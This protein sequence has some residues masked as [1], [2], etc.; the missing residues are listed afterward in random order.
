MFNMKKFIMLFAAFA[1]LCSCSKVGQDS[2]E[3]NTYYFKTDPS[4]EESLRSLFQADTLNV[5]KA[6]DDYA[7]VNIARSIVSDVHYEIFREDGEFMYSSDKFVQSTGSD[8]T[9][10]DFYWNE[11]VIFNGVHYYMFVGLPL[12]KGK[13][14]SP[15]D[16]CGDFGEPLTRVLTCN[17]YW[18]IGDSQDVDGAQKRCHCYTSDLN[19][20]CGTKSYYTRLFFGGYNHHNSNYYWID[21]SNAKNTVL[22]ELSNGTEKAITGLRL[23]KGDGKTP[24]EEITDPATGIVWRLCDIFFDGDEYYTADNRRLGADLNDGAAG[25]FLYLYRTHDTR[26]GR[27]LMLVNPNLMSKTSIMHTLNDE[28]N[29]GVLG[30]GL[31]TWNFKE[32]AYKNKENLSVRAIM[33]A[34]YDAVDYRFKPYWKYDT[35]EQRVDF[36]RLYD[37]NM[38]P[39]DEGMPASFNRNARGNEEY[40]M[41]YNFITADDHS[42]WSK[43]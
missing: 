22:K 32:S 30:C 9:G 18:Y 13:D 33:N 4:N 20:G 2:N 24:K 41:T 1:A 27:K 17:N 6:E 8:S 34:V 40:I 38:N 19:G 16:S 25:D 23:L 42:S 37:M 39:I 5:F 7:V 12:P 14:R 35:K 21:Q 43:Y 10:D 3:V 11:A 29:E 28:I 15:Y 36:I 26:T 31:V